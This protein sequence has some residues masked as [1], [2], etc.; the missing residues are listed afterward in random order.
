MYKKEIMKGSG[1]MGVG[2]EQD[3]FQNTQK[4]EG[5]IRYP[6][7]V[8]AGRKIRSRNKK[9]ESIGSHK[10]KEMD[11]HF[12][13]QPTKGRRSNANFPIKVRYHQLHQTGDP[14]R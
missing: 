8:F 7:L 1:L 3:R 14:L 10:V 12:N 13:H 5:L 6:L 9:W 2:E 4:L 11:I